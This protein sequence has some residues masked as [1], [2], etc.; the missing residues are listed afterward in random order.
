MNLMFSQNGS[1]QDNLFFIPYTDT[2][3]AW[4][5]S[6]T[7]VVTDQ[8]EIDQDWDLPAKDV[9]SGTQSGLA[10]R[11]R[12]MSIW[13]C[14]AN[15]TDPTN[16]QLY[17]PPTLS[18]DIDVTCE[19][20]VY[21]SSRSSPLQIGDSESSP[22]PASRKVTWTFGIE[23]D[24]NKGF[25]SQSSTT[26]YG[27]GIYMSVFGTR[28]NIETAERTNAFAAG[29]DQLKVS[30]DVTSDWSIGDRLMLSGA[31]YSAGGPN[32]DFRRTEM[33]S[34]NGMSYSGGETTITLDSNVV[35][36]YP[37]QHPSP[38]R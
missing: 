17:V 10:D 38:A 33:R 11:N 24:R 8:I 5:T 1:S 14:A 12:Y 29:T 28:P 27:R 7:L 13:C 37:L 16:P 25:F 6:D 18:A 2:Q 32:Y 26:T 30:G 23:T 4:T 34:I 19:G 31:Q 36:H 9:T 15:L 21:L 35:S 3:V 22:I 20:S